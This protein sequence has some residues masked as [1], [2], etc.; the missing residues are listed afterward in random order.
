MQL[1]KSRIVESG[2]NTT[3]LAIF[4]IYNFR[5]NCCAVR[6][7]LEESDTLLL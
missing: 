6:Y 4:S 2:N 5:I 7:I 1:R 3:V